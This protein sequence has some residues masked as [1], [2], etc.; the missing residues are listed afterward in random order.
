[1]DERAERVARRSGLILLRVS[2]FYLLV[3]QVSVWY[4]KLA[5]LFKTGQLDAASL[6]SGL[7]TELLPE[8]LLS[9]WPLLLALILMGIRWPHLVLAAILSLVAFGCMDIAQAGL[10]G[11]M[12]LKPGPGCWVTGL[13]RPSVVVLLTLR[14]VLA[15]FAAFTLFRLRKPW[16]RQVRGVKG[17][18]SQPPAILGRLSLAITGIFWLG[19]LAV[20]A[21]KGFTEVGLRDV[22]L[23]RW[24]AFEPTNSRM[25]PTQPEKFDPDDVRVFQGISEIE[26]ADRQLFRGQFAEARRLFGRGLTALADDPKNENLQNRVDQ[27]RAGGFNNL[28][29]LLCTSPDLSLRDYTLAAEFA[30]KAVE[31]LPKDGNYW[32]TLGAAALGAGEFEES[33]TALEKSVSLRNGGTAHD[34]LFLAQ[35]EEKLDHPQESARWLEKAESYLERNGFPDA[36]M[37]RLYTEASEFLGVPAKEFA[38]AT[39]SSLRSGPP[40]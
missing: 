25:R 22:R 38:N 14:G 26:E 32:N 36:E 11:F 33:K 31:L 28:A 30:R 15:L 16:K 17:M 8:F 35:V 6:T 23:Q 21:W 19:C 9:L 37:R 12:K 1:M 18:S 3:P 24:I 5:D 4:M 2:L 34:W 40:D 39:R 20:P 27:V 13:T 7:S 10:M 29:W